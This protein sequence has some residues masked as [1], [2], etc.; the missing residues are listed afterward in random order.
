MLNEQ[1]KQYKISGF[2]ITVV[3][4]L[5]VFIGWHLLFEGLSKILN[6][7]WTAA[8]Y[9]E[10]SQWLFSGIFQ[11]VVTHDTVLLTVDWLNMLGLTAIGLALFI[12][13]F[14]KTA[15]T[16]GIVMLA[17]YYIANP[18]FIAGNFGIPVEGHYLFINKILIEMIGLAV[19]A[20]FPSYIMPG[21]DRYLY[22][23]R[24][25]RSLPV[26]GFEK[27][28]Q[29]AVQ[30]IPELDQKGMHRRELLKNFASIPF[31]GAF[32]YG[33]ARKY[34]WESINA[35]TGA[36]IK[37]SDTN[38][39]RLTG[40]LPKGKIKDLEIS[41]IIMG[42]NL[43]GGW[44]HSR[45]LH[46]VPSLFKAYNTETKIFETLALS[47]KAGVN[48]MNITHSQFPV[49]NKY[50]RVMGSNLQTISQIH[51]TKED[52]Y[53][54]VDKVIDNGVDLIQIQ[55]NCCDWRVRA[56]EI[57][58]LVKCI[59]YIRQQGY[60]AGLGAHSIQALYACDEAGI[61]PDFYMKT[62]HHDRYWS[63]HPKENR[64][65][66]SVDGER[67]PNH[68]EFHDNM[69]CLFPEKTIEFMSKKNIPFIAFK[70]L[71]GGAIKPEDGIRYAFDNGADFVCVGMF[72]YQIV[73]DVNIALNVLDR[74][75]QR[76]RLWF[77]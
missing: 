57:D 46:Y 32:L 53:G 37:V 70:V 38:L 27:D 9:L 55:G 65:P 45:D 25:S 39:R 35:I 12:G 13:F 41:R 1:N 28:K 6:P 17:L 43:I 51:P 74:V 59:D 60:P 26:T 33:T 8:G 4:V 69:F 62:L 7:D 42:G 14:T 71:A 44:A 30:G 40:N 21:I 16:L 67:S 18:P 73:D 11:W 66:F 77:S 61:E 22:L 29:E 54:H 68:D 76:D 15:S 47:E 49:I 3:T 24:K 52:I 19:I 31:L 10:K 23:K 58:V 50:K 34:R 75:N 36:T 63:A 72:D 20:A 5:R 2:Q 64:I 56:G 48:T